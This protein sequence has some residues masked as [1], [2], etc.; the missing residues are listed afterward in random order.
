MRFSEIAVCMALAGGCS[1]V[2]TQ[3]DASVPMSEMALGRV[4]V[5]RQ[6]AIDAGLPN[7]EAA[8]TDAVNYLE[9]NSQDELGPL[10]GDVLNAIRGEL[11]GRGEDSSEIAQLMSRG[12]TFMQALADVQKHNKE[13]VEE[14]NTL[15]DRVELLKLEMTEWERE[16]RRVTLARL[17]G[18]V[19]GVVA[20]LV[21]LIYWS[22]KKLVAFWNSFAT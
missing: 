22:R 15:L 18:F 17:V 10:D 6:A 16:A 3:R 19:L 2:P 21:G 12:K 11:S 14:R 5:V 1:V 8:L 4:L 7:T 20:L 9:G 13:L